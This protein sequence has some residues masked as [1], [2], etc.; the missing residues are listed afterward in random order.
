MVT[1]VYI[2]V[3]AALLSAC[4]SK[5]APITVPEGAQAGD[6]VNLEPCSY[7]ANKVV[8]DADCGTLV[9]PE[10]RSD[11]NSRLIAMPNYCCHDRS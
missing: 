3:L 1:L 4:G 10:N 6:L 2:A 8:Y 11:P 7:E 5:E 9:V